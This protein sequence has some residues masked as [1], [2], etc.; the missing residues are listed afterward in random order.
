MP[1]ERRHRC[2]N[3][4]TAFSATVGTVFHCTHLPLRKWFAAV[5]FILDAR[6]PISARN[7]ARQLDINKNTAWQLNRRI[8]LALLEPSQRDILLEIADMNENYLDYGASISQAE[9]AA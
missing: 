9:G 5:S 8:G 7:L 2:N 1:K 4:N 3:C 6:E